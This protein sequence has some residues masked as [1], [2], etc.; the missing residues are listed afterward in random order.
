MNKVVLPLMKYHTKIVRLET[1]NPVDARV[2]RE[3]WQKS[4]RTQDQDKR[5]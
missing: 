3:R 4:R 5:G 2:K 1:G